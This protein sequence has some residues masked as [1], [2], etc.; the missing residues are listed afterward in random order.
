MLPQYLNIKKALSSFHL[1][2]SL[3]L[4]AISDRPSEVFFLLDITYKNK[5]KNIN[6]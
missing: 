6:K 1:Y 2:R 4:P 3:S 5:Y